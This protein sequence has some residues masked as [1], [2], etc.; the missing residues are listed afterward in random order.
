ML[1]LTSF[2]STLIVVCVQIS[3]LWNCSQLVVSVCC[4]IKGKFIRNPESFISMCRL[5]MNWNGSLVYSLFFDDFLF[6]IYGIYC[7]VET[8]ALFLR[9][10][11]ICYT[12]ASGIGIHMFLAAPLFGRIKLVGWHLKLMISVYFWVLF[13]FLFFSQI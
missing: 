2:L 13:V 8:I 3:H 5:G 9:C 6:F 7:V 10:C 11:Y 4:T 12:L 1:S